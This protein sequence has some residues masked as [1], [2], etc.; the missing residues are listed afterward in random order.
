[1]VNGDEKKGN[2]SKWGKYYD[3]LFTNTKEKER[4]R[5]HTVS[6]RPTVRFSRKKKTFISQDEWKEE[7]IIVRGICHKSNQSLYE[8]HSNGSHFNFYSNIARTYYFQCATSPVGY[9]KL[10]L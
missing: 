6:L 5:G 4:V 8:F 7:L 3:F 2:E 9:Y 1:M 10:S